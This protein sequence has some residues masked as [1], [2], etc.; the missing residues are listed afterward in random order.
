MSNVLFPKLA[1]FASATLTAPPITTMRHQQHLEH[2]KS[3]AET[4]LS[5]LKKLNLRNYAAPSVSPTVHTPTTAAARTEEKLEFVNGFPAHLSVHS[6]ENEKE[7]KEERLREEGA[8]RA[9]REQ[10]SDTESEESISTPFP[11]SPN[12]IALGNA[13]GV[14]TGIKIRSR[15]PSPAEVRILAGS[16]NGEICHDSYSNRL[17]LLY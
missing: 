3:I 13:S 11:T 14:E 10:E 2:A 17:F 1:S 16:E 12:S 4:T 5:K 8:V 7:A 6:I 9:R 15:T